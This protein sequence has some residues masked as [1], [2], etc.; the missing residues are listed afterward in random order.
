MMAE[1]AGQRL[2]HVAKEHFDKRVRWRNSRWGSGVTLAILC[3]H[4]IDPVLQ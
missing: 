1:F 4:L 2:C 3:R